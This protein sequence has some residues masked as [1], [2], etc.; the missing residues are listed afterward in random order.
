[1]GK[2]SFKE[3]AQYHYNSVDRNSKLKSANDIYIGQKRKIFT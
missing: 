1:M 2:R 3:K